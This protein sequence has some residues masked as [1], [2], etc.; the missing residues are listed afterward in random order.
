MSDFAWKG[1]Y[2]V[3]ENSM[4]EWNNKRHECSLGIVIYN[5][6]PTLPHSKRSTLILTSPI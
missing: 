1:K 2:G 5:F 6:D 3:I 4:S